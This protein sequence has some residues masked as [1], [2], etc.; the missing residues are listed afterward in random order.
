MYAADKFSESGRYFPF[1]VRV[2][3][4]LF[5]RALC[6]GEFSSLFPALLS[7]FLPRKFYL[8]QFYQPKQRRIPS[9]PDIVFAFHGG[10]HG[11]LR[12][13]VFGLQSLRARYCY[14]LPRHDFPLTLLHNSSLHNF[15]PQPH[16]LYCIGDLCLQA[17]IYHLLICHL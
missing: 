10:A 2:F 16:L 3:S 8:R 1:D 15:L 7:V 13:C 6:Y 4:H 9:L 12:Y 5:I 11:F 14:L 17:R